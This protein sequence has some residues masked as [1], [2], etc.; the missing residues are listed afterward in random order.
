MQVTQLE[1]T[2]GV[3]YIVNS[4]KPYPPWIKE[5]TV[6]KSMEKIDKVF[7]KIGLPNFKESC[8][9]MNSAES[10]TEAARLG[11][12]LVQVITAAQTQ[13]YAKLDE[14]LT[15][16]E[17]DRGELCAK[18]QELISLITTLQYS[19]R[20]ADYAKVAEGRV[21]L[22]LR[23]DIFNAGDKN[24]V[25][26]KDE[27][28]L[29]VIGK[30][31]DMCLEYKIKFDA[32][33]QLPEFKDFSRVN[34]PNKKYTVAFSSSGEDG[35]WDIGTISMRGVTSCQSWNAPQSR[36]LIGS[37]SSKF[38]GVIYLAS[39]Q[40]IPGYGTKMLNRSVVRF[41]INKKTK[42]PAL[43]M[44][45]M[46]PNMNQDTLAVF[47]K[48]LKD[49]SGLDVLYTYDRDPSM[50]DYYLPDE[51]ARKHLK[52]GE[53]SYMD[54]QIPVL[55]HAPS[56]KKAPANITAMTDE[57]KK[58]VG[59]ELDRMVK[60]KRELFDAATKQLE[61]LKTEYSVAKEKWELENKDKPEDQ[62]IKFQFE[63]PKMDPEL[64]AF[65][66]GGVENLFKHCDKK[67]GAN[68]AGRMFSKFI[69]DSLPAP[70]E[71]EYTSKEEYHRKYLMGF[72]K[73]TK[74]AKEVSW[75][76]VNG[77]TWMKSFPRSSEKFYNYI[78]SQM[79]G[80]VVDSCKEMI[81]KSNA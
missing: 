47:K 59:D 20:F 40:E 67:H 10:L 9:I 53:F 26:R 21:V 14:A 1:Q 18:I 3:D 28:L 37:I 7:P 65:G 24:P 48:V 34:V 50:G 54:H 45:N 44:D 69:L 19:L 25:F 57:F 78:F 81:K 6:F 29:R 62:R 38:V 71:G 68:S 43:I 52:Q 15:S 4:K 16:K 17:K 60:T 22:K 27:A 46:Y 61:A 33:D 5:H 42:K 56:I 8:D 79:K 80:Y 36:G 32:I 11:N 75:K 23:A 70:K 2:K 35:A 73:S 30:L 76:A 74:A 51:P 39:D 72:L 41:C 64:L 58:K 63:E 77:G 49:K 55:A 12:R 13:L 66:K 31:R